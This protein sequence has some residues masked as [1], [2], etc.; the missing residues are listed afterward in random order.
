MEQ[1]SVMVDDAF[2]KLDYPTE[3]YYTTCKFQSFSPAR[4]AMAGDLAV[5]IHKLTEH[6]RNY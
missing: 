6:G 2:V 4:L 3:Y 5:W 1:R